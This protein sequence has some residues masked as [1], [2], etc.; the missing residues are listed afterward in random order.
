MIP[1]TWIAFLAFVAVML[2]LDLGV[3]NKKSH[4]MSV[5]EA[6]SWTAFWIVLAL[7]FNFILYYMYEH[8][9]GIPLSAHYMSGKE[10]AIKFLTGYIVEK[11]LSLDNIF[12]IATIFNFY[13][14]PN[15][16]QHRVLFWGILGALVMRGAMIFAGTALMDRFHWLIY[17]FGIFLIIT[18]IKMLFAKEDDNKDLNQ[19]PFVKAVKAFFPLD[20]EIKDE[21]FFIKKDGKRM[22]TPLFLV[23]VVIEF[24]DVIFAVDSIPAVMAVT[25]DPFIVF[26]SNIFAILGLR[27]LYF[28]FAA[29]MGKFKYLKYSVIVL[30]AYV[31]IKMLLSHIYPIPTEISLAFIVGVI[32]AGM[33]ISKKKATP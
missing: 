24:S 5:K 22:I 15:L 17:V 21:S 14:I 31:G 18:A 28:A 27:S 4:V 7:I 13:K 16:Y 1:V 26:T 3:F 29:I 11:T 2:F 33:A 6:L 10:A 32:I 9:W 19:N 23:L 20:P 30:L 12:V 25:T 8:R